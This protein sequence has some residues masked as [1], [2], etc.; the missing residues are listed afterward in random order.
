MTCGAWGVLA[1][2]TRNPNGRENPYSTHT[3][4]WGV[5]PKHQARRDDTYRGVTVDVLYRKKPSPRR[6]MKVNVL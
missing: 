5:L 2:P 1:T 3:P 6:R 4:T